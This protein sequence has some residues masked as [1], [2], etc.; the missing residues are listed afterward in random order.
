MSG[1]GGGPTLVA[2]SGGASTGGAVTGTG[3]GIGGG[4]A[5]TTGPTVAAVGGTGAST[6]GPTVVA[7]GGTG[8]SIT[9]LVAPQDAISTYCIGLYKAK[10]ALSKELFKIDSDEFKYYPNIIIEKV[11]KDTTDANHILITIKGGNQEAT[12][13][14]SGFKNLLNASP[15]ELIENATIPTT[16]D[17][18]GGSTNADIQDFIKQ[19]TDYSYVPFCMI[20]QFYMNPDS[21]LTKEYSPYEL[22][23]MS[24]LSF[25]PKE[26]QKGE[27]MCDYNDTLIVGTDFLATPATTATPEIP[28]SIKT[29]DA[30]KGI[31]LKKLASAPIL[32]NSKYDIIHSLIASKP[33]KGIIRGGGLK[34]CRGT[35]CPNSNLPR[36]Y[37]QVFEK[38]TDYY[39]YA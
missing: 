10:K 38:R 22:S 37:R 29:F 35:S 19:I 1:K 34:S 36:I 14:Y 31:K 4:G 30:L 27:L 21:I 25:D 23:L 18:L 5:S 16:V 15:K 24:E 28:P 17:L 12:M 20:M 3:T 11:E 2:V 6:T 8:A 26:N 39:N 33:I 7:V 13:H 32:K 9:T